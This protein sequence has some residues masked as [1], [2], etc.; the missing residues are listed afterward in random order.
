MKSYA[1]LSNQCLDI[2]TTRLILNGSII[3][4]LFLE[5]ILFFH[6]LISPSI[7]PEKHLLFTSSVLV[8]LL[9]AKLFLYRHHRLITNWI[10]I[11]SYIFLTAVTLLV[12]GINSPTA[13]L[14]VGFAVIVPGILIGAWA[15]PIVVTI[16]ISVMVFVQCLHSFAIFQPDL[17]H[18]SF[19]ST[20]WDVASYATIITIFGLVAWLASIHREN[21]LRRALVAEKALETQKATLQDELEKETALLRQTQL[22]QLHELHNFAVLGQSAA[23]TL[24]ELSNQLSVLNLDISDLAQHHNNSLAIRRAKESIDAVNKM[25]RQTRTQLQTYNHHQPFDT[26][27][28]LKQCERDL[29]EKF[30]NHA[31]KL[32][33]K[34]PMGASKFITEGSPYA[35]MQIMTILLNNA[36]DACRDTPNAIVTVIVEKSPT[37]AIVSVI[38]NGPGIAPNYE[39]H[40]FSP[41]MSTKPNGLG[42]GLYIARYLA[43]TQLNSKVGTLPSDQ[44]AHFFIKIPKVKLSLR[45]KRREKI[46]DRV[47]V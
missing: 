3:I 47:H 30:I 11:T 35:L 24:H 39:T 20:F 27:A 37:H 29:R 9:V 43:R 22:K 10:L 14:T 15:I 5:F 23:A 17:K 46:S 21:N 33:M 34:F 1:P 38:D 40:L 13:I 44:G 19:A 4:T 25:V 16:V 32:K 18:P 36:L 7:Q 8:I 42:V 41:L 6:H 12:W 45:H 28:I 31:V 2:R 26:I